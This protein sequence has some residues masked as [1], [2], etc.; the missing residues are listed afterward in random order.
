MS[1]LAEAPLENLSV[2]CDT[3]AGKVRRE[4]GGLS[5]GKLGEC[6]GQGSL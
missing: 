1:Q 4:V 2:L 6:A 3:P 5:L